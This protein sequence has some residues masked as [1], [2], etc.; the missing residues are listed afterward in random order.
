MKWNFSVS[1][2]SSAG[3]GSAL[4]RSAVSEHQ[5]IFNYR[6]ANNFTPQPSSRRPQ[7]K[8]GKNKM[9]PCTLKFF[10]LA[11]IDYDK[12]PC[13]IASKTALSNCGLGAGSITLDVNSPSIHDSLLEKFPLPAAAAG[14]ELL[15]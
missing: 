12:P 10:C 5:R 7:N 1:D 8:K 6:A 13:N 14:Y 4:P 3:N 15:S 2:N 11:N 9:Q